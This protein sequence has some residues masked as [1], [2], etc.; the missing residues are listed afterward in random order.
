MAPHPD[1]RPNL[2]FSVELD[3]TGIRAPETAEPVA[4]E[5]SPYGGTIDV[6]G[7]TSQQ[8]AAP[9]ASRPGLFGMAASAATSMARFAASG[10]ETVR[11]EVHEARV[12]QCARCEHHVGVRCTVCG[13]FTDKKAWLPHEDCPIGRWPC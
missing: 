4:P 11:P 9:P 13:C 3:P 5:V 10:F 8:Q 7:D 2:G 12:Q 6:T 1:D